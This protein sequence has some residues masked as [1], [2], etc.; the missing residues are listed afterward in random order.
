MRPNTRLFVKSVATLFR[1]FCHILYPS[2]CMHCAGTLC[3][4]YKIFCAACREQFSLISSFARCV[5][6]FQDPC[7]C[8]VSRCSKRKRRAALWVRLG[9]CA[10]WIRAL[11][12]GE[13]AYLP[14]TIAFLQLQFA[15]LQWSMPEYI[16]S[17]PFSLLHAWR[18]GGNLP[19][20]LAKGFA[21]AIGCRVM[22]PFRMCLDRSAFLA[23]GTLRGVFVLRKRRKYHLVGKRILLIAHSLCDEHL[24]QVEDLLT[25]LLPEELYVLALSD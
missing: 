1:G 15:H 11:E 4:P 17:L 3:L 23:E 13:F 16:V 5:H 18:C 7:I 10:T 2:F 19:S 9:P 14:T 20:L 25:T 24:L 6:C 22:H 12:R 8:S 21:Q